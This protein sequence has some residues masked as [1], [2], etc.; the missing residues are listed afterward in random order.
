MT[1]GGE[2]ATHF[3]TAAALKP[4]D[5]VFAQYREAGVLSE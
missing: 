5:E 4:D 3:G 2:E 1:N